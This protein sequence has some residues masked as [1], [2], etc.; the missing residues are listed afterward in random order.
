MVWLGEKEDL[1]SPLVPHMCLGLAY[2]LGTGMAGLLVL[3]PSDQ[4]LIGRQYLCQ[5]CLAGAALAQLALQAL[6][7]QRGYLLFA[8]LY[9]ALAGGAHFALRSLVL[10]TV[11][12]RAAPRAWALVQCSQSLPALVGLPVTS[13]LL[14]SCYL[15]SPE[16][17][18]KG[19]YFSSACTLLSSGAL[20]FLNL[21][22]HYLVNVLRPD[23]EKSEPEP[24]APALDQIAEECGGGGVWQAGDVLVTGCARAAPVYC[25]PSLA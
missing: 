13:K 10:E 14:L 17:P 21:R 22:R 1:E 12:C 20:F 25:Q 7:D 6:S 5:G 19:F 4:C 2:S 23:E 11:T 8:W 24:V 15:S 18:K 16:Q 9:G 3:C